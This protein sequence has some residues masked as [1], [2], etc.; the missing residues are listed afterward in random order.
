MFFHYCNGRLGS[1]FLLYFFY[2]FMF[3]VG[4]QFLKEYGTP[5]TM[6]KK[7]YR[8]PKNLFTTCDKI[9]LLFLPCSHLRSL[10]IPL[11]SWV[12]ERLL[13]LTG[14]AYLSPT[15]LLSVFSGESF[16]FLA[17]LFSYFSPILG[18]PIWS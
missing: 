8:I 11:N 13:A 12:S 14:H 10:W 18:L 2:F 15:N 17:C 7:I 16:L 9:L 4:L 6:K 3:N 5:S 1:S